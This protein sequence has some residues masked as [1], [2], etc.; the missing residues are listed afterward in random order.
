MEEHIRTNSRRKKAQTGTNYLHVFI[1]PA[2]T[3]HKKSPLVINQRACNCMEFFMLSLF[4]WQRVQ[5]LL[6][7]YH[8]VTANLPVPVLCLLRS[9]ERR[10]GKGCR[11][12][13]W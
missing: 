6:S 4:W 8:R 3:G 7:S 2:T 10:V 11:V 1:E 9:E 12:W 5:Q 13:R